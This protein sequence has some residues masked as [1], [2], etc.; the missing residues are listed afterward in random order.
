MKRLQELQKLEETMKSMQN[1][2][3]TSKTEQFQI[4]N[5]INHLQ[6]EQ[7]SLNAEI[8]QIDYQIGERELTKYKYFP[9]FYSIL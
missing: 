5:S 8:K 2:L 7:N 3:E 4:R 6:K 1:L 9:F